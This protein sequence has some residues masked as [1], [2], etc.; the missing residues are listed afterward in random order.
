MHTSLHQK[1]DDV[2][3]PGSRGDVEGSLPPRVN[4]HRID[5]AT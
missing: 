5:V 3:V 4:R 1:L 2:Y